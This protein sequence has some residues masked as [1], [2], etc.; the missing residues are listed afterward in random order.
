MPIE[1]S[2][3]PKTHFSGLDYDNIIEDIIHIVKDNPQY[4]SNWDDFLSSNSGRML[5]ELFAYIADM[6]TTRIDWNVNENYIG[7]ATQKKSVIK[8]LKL[9]GYDFQLPIASKVDVS[10]SL[11]R[12]VGDFYLT[13]IYENNGVIKPYTLTA[14][15]KS[16]ETRNF[17]CLEYD[18]ANNRYEYKTGIKIESGTVSNPNLEHLVEFYE[19]E[20]VIDPFVADT[21][22]NPIFTLTRSPVVENSV[23]VYL[24]KVSGVTTTEEELVKVRSFLD[25]EAQREED[26]FGNLLS[27]PYIQHVEEDDTVTIEFGPTSLLANDNRR[28]RLGDQIRIFYRVGGG[29]NSNITKN[30]INVTKRIIAGIPPQNINAT[31]VNEN[32]GVNGADGETAEHAAVYAPLEVRTANKLVTENDYDILINSNNTVLKSKSYGCNNMP[33]DLY[34]KYGVFIKPLEIWNFVLKKK[35]GWEAIYP[36]QYNDFRWI[37]LRLENRFNEKHKLR[38]GEFN[39]KIIKKNEGIVQTQDIDFDGNGVATFKNFVILEMPDKF[40]DNLFIGASP[41]SNLKLKVCME[42]ADDQFFNNLNPSNIFLEEDTTN[43]GL[44]EGVTPTWSVYQPKHASYISARDVSNDLSMSSRKRTNLSFDGRDLLELNFVEGYQEFTSTD[45]PVNCLTQAYTFKLDLNGINFN[46]G[47]DISVS[48]T[49]GDSLTTIAT[50]LAAAINAITANS[51]LVEKNITSGKLRVMSATMGTPSAVSILAPGAGSS[52][53]T[54]LGGVDTAIDAIPVDETQVTST[55]LVS[56]INKTFLEHSG[57][58]GSSIGT[59][60]SQTLGIS[61]TDSDDC[62]L[63][64]AV[65][66]YIWINGKEYSIT[67]EADVIGDVTNGSAWITNVEIPGDIEKVSAGLSVIGPGVPVNTVVTLVDVVNNRF[68][69]DQNATADN[70]GSTLKLDRRYT[71]IKNLLTEAFT[72]VIKGDTVDNS[73]EIINVV[74][75]HDIQQ[76]EPGMAVSGTGIP[77]NTF[78]CAVNRLAKSFSL[79]DGSGIPVVATLTDEQIDISL[80]GIEVEITGGDFKF[81]NIR[82]NPVGPIWIEHSTQTDDLLNT[83]TGFSD[84]VNNAVVPSGI[85]GYQDFGL[86]VATVA[87]SGYQGCGLTEK[88]LTKQT[89]LA[90]L[91]TYY[92]KVNVDASGEIEY[93]ITFAGDTTYGGMIGLMNALSYDQGGGEDVTWSVINYNLVCSSVSTGVTSTIELSAGTTGSNLF[94]GI[95]GF[96]AFDTAVAGVN[97]ENTPLTPSTTYDFKVN[98]HPY[99]ITTGIGTTSY[100]DLISLLNGVTNFF[101]N[102]TTSLVGSD[103]S[104]DLRIT[105]DT[106][107][108]V[109]LSAGDTNDLFTALSTTPTN[110]VGGGDYSAVAREIQN[111]T[112]SYIEV[113]SPCCGNSSNIFFGTYTNAATDVT[114]YLF[115][116]NANTDRQC[117]GYNKL[118]VITNSGLV[119]DYGNVIFENGSLSFVESPKNFY[120]NYLMSDT[121]KIYIGRYHYD[122]FEE[123]DPSWREKANRIYNTVYNVDTQKIDLE[124]STFEVK[125]TAEKETESLSIFSIQN[126]WGMV[127]SSPASVDSIVNPGVSGNLNTTNYKIKI[128][129]DGQGSVEIDLTGNAGIGGGGIP[130]AAYDLTEIVDNINI[131]ITN[132]G[133]YTTD[134]VYGTYQY[135]VVHEDGN[136]ITI[137]SPYNT[138][139]SNIDI[140]T[141]LGQDATKE[142]F[143]LREG[144]THTFKVVGDYYLDYDAT[145]N[146]MTLNR[147]TAS[148][149]YPI[150]PDLE[151]YLHFVFDKRFVADVYDGTDGRDGYYE[152]SLDEDIYGTSLENN[153][154]VGLNNIFKETKISTFDVFGIVYYSKIYSA[155]DVEQ[156]VEEILKE[157]FKIENRDYREPVARSKVMNY[158]HQADGVDYVEISY[159]GNDATDSTTNVENKI[160]CDFDEIIVLSEDI[161]LGGNQ[162]HGLKFDYRISEF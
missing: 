9:I 65:T 26:N 96:T 78:V 67:T 138:N 23:R 120:A 158:I 154:I 151:F 80:Y 71:D 4:N 159:L 45:D 121:D 101:V 110:Q 103:S 149:T 10:L 50:K 59:Q 81:T 57:Y 29:V 157:A 12:P 28:L 115:N 141:P 97:V 77:P 142:F 73:N 33:A 130:G 68:Q 43:N 34:T 86:S 83:L 55:E 160:E 128:N 87:T 8:T 109:S 41:N 36:S 107:A 25:P 124:N 155:A 79:V 94:A 51:V 6:I 111:D 162:I 91:N 98:N 122:N 113:V 19:G 119:N 13:P 58:N 64:E 48:L 52:L 20:T 22:N 156:N 117:Y 7:T 114:F 56:T 85:S 123:T 147:I 92:F 129:I 1:L 116:F 54:L 153:K 63:T 108:C 144:I 112:F 125:F 132:D 46:G 145:E 18:E 88:T 72:F 35:S 126:S 102:Y 118:T 42:E 3:L 139:V 150:L 37:T 104:Q 61:I 47:A 2:K 69:I 74:Y 49:A 134:P 31:F 148:G 143:D 66:Y 21:S 27:L 127:E 146:L 95:S 16:G 30:S 62:G 100:L 14:K 140:E 133:N 84:P 90:D 99:S 161:F 89:G 32:E 17:E 60:G 76:I 152:G 135:A 53:I 131:T 24:V 75:N 82:K 105:S 38:D 44:I 5:I 39:Y 136:K 11:D 137:R 40:K 93:S 15:D 106:T 70:S